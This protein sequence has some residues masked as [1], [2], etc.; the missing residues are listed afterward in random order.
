MQGDSHRRLSPFV[1][2]RNVLYA[3]VYI[4]SDVFYNTLHSPCYGPLKTWWQ[5]SFIG[6]L[7]LVYWFRKTRNRYVETRLCYRNSL[8]ILHLR[9]LLSSSRNLYEEE[10]IISN[11]STKCMKLKFIARRLNTAQHT[12]GILLPIIRSLWTAIA[13][14]G[15]PLESV[16]ILQPITQQILVINV[17]CHWLHKLIYYCKAQ[18]DGSYQNRGKIWIAHFGL[19]YWTI[20]SVTRS[21]VKKIRAK[22]DINRID[23]RMC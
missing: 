9:V 8:V 4:T 11:K 18:R 19:Q 2:T 23:L 1:L 22:K 3:Q 16:V 13:A 7:Y 6:L 20:C 5:H 21:C 15:L 17:L 14:Y 12:S 10:L